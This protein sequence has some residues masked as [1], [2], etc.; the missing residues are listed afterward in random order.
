VVPRGI[1]VETTGALLVVDRALRAVVRIDPVSGE[2]RVL[3]D[4]MIGVGP[5]FSDPVDIMVESTDQIVVLDMGL[6]A[7]VRVEAQ[8]GDRAIISR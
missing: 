5:V 4:D 7:I 1:A 2:R 6:R 3:S 8:H